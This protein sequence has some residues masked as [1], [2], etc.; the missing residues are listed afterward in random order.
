MTEKFS[1]TIAHGEYYAFLDKVVNK[2]DNKTEET[3]HWSG[4]KNPVKDN[5][6]GDQ[7]DGSSSDLLDFLSADSTIS[8]LQAALLAFVSGIEQ[9]FSQLEE[10][11]EQLFANIVSSLDSS[12]DISEY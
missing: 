9:T 6:Q 12:F 1:F 3:L 4:N 11:A 8:E 5:L 10:D 2:I 7:E